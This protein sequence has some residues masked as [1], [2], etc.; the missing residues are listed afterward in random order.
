MTP[1]SV[2][3]RFG[4]V[5]ARPLIARQVRRNMAVLRG[6]LDELGRAPLDSA[7]STRA[8]TVTPGGRPPGRPGPT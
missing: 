3:F 1:V 2:G 4:Y 5:F 6:L 8:G 7:R